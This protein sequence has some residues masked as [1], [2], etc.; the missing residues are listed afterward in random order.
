MIAIPTISEW[1]N[2]YD[3]W[4]RPIGKKWEIAYVSYPILPRKNDSEYEILKADPRW[5]EIYHPAH[6]GT[7]FETK[8]KEAADEFNQRKL[9]LLHDSQ[10]SI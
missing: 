4:A 1:G 8:S 2:F 5:K 3:G 9:W 10:P 7:S 6:A